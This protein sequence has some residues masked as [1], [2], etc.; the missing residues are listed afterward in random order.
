MNDKERAMI[1]TLMFMLTEV[2]QREIE[3]NHH[4]DG[5]EGC[6]NCEAIAEAQALH[7]IPEPEP[8][9]ESK[10]D[11]DTEPEAKKVWYAAKS[12]GPGQGLVIDE[13]DGRNVAVAY[14]EKDT[15]LLA[16][17]PEL[18]NA[19]IEVM[20][21][22]ENWMEIAEDDDKR[23]YDEDAMRDGRAALEKAGMRR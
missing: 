14:D 1:D 16:A 6:S 22:L 3:E 7:G 4:G 17:A 21:S 11:G 10:Q 18:A 8:D 13:S 9:K 23:D 20:E 2:H 19:L 12:A 15:P 5:P